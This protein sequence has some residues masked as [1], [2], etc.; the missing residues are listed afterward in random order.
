MIHVFPV[1]R[2]GNQMFEYAF[3]RVLMKH[4]PDQLVS[5]HWD[6]LKNY[7]AESEG[8]KNS[9]KDFCT[10]STEA[11][12]PKIN[13]NIVQRLVYYLYWLLHPKTNQLSKLS[14]F[15]RM[16]DPFVGNLGLYYHGLNYFPYRFHHKGDIIVSGSFEVVKY[17]DKYRDLLLKEFT[18]RHERMPQ[19]VDLYSAIEQSNSVCVTIRRG[20]FLLQ[21]NQV[22]NVCSIDYYYQA[23]SKIRELIPNAVLFF[24]SDDIDWVRQNIIID[25]SVECYY[26]SGKDPL[27]EKLRLM[28]SC[29]HFI[30]SNSTFSWWAQYLGNYKE[31]KVIAPNRWFNNNFIPE[32][33]QDNWIRINI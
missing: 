16:V 31:K 27:W 14:K 29:K 32:L 23:I 19:N 15:Q 30:I 22:H 17:F 5:W 20:D 4:N 33:L 26:E 21:K 24:F 2:L 25:K 1:G 28:Y 3:V 6:E 12:P 10:I 9:L 13:L 8:W 7:G 18:P 11:I